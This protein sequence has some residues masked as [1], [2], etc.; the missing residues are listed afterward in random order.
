[1]ESSKESIS[2]QKRKAA[3]KYKIIVFLITAFL[4]ASLHSTR[5]SWAYAKPTISESI[6]FSKYYFGVLDS[7]FLGAYA[8]GLYLS[9]WLGDRVGL[10]YLLTLGLVSASLSFASFAVIEGLLKERSLYLDCF[11]F[12]ID[13]LGQSTVQK[14]I[15]VIPGLPSVC[16]NTF[17]LVFI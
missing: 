16:C 14:K 9:G 13:G 6:N 17:E 12:I 15:I 2:P 1:M 8:I 11:A 5:T 10:K 3:L 4:Y 7:C